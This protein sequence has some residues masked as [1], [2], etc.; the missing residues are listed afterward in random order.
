MLKRG[1]STKHA[2]GVQLFFKEEVRSH[3]WRTPD[4]RRL[5][6]NLSREIYKTAGIN[7]LVAVADNLFSGPVV[8]EKIFPV[9]L[10]EKLTAEFADDE[11]RLFESWLARITS[12]AD[13]DALVHELIGPMIVAEPKRVPVVFEWAKAPDRWHRRAACVAL[14]RGARRKQFFPQITRLSNLMLDQE[15]EMVEKGLSWLLRETAKANPKR[16]I[17]YLMK[18]RDRAPRRVLRTACE[19]LSP[20]ERLPVLGF[21]RRDRLAGRRGGLR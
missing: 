5:A 10:L 14:I 6:H 18:I 17:P 13:H 4:L 1:G 15:D 19:T 8:E 2:Q 16:T 7:F 12:W 11:F 21:A 9:L 20:A 3:G